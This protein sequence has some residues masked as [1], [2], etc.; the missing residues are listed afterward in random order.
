MKLGTVQRWV[1]DINVNTLEP[2][3]QKVRLLD[4][5][6]RCTPEFKQFPLDENQVGQGLVHNKGEWAATALQEEHTYES[7]QY[8]P[9]DFKVIKYEKAAER[10]PP[11]YYD[12][13]IFTN[14]LEFN[15][16]ADTSAKPVERHNVPGIPGAFVLANVLSPAQCQ[17]IR[18]MADSM[19]F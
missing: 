16:D 8:Q 12:L 15:F 6:L 13:S 3:A 10:I 14:L 5:V 7:N 4:L 1:R 11:N 17:Q 9:E 18:N 2:E 19:G